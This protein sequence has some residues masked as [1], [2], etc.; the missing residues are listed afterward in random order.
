MHA[1]ARPSGVRDCTTPGHRPRNAG[2]V[3]SEVDDT[4]DALMNDPDAPKPPF[5]AGKLASPAPVVAP[6]PATPAAATA[7]AT[8][9]W[10][11]VTP[12]IDEKS[13]QAVV[14]PP[15]L[16]KLALPTLGNPAMPALGGPPTLGPPSVAPPSPGVA[17]STLTSPTVGVVSATPTAGATSVKPRTRGWTMFMEVTEEEAVAAPTPAAAP[18]AAP[19]LTP[20]V[21]AV[22]P[23]PT[24]PSGEVKPST[25]GW[26]MLMD[27]PAQADPVALVPATPPAAATSPARPTTRGWTMIEELNDSLPADPTPM[28]M[29]TPATTGVASEASGNSNAP[30]SRGWTMLMEAELQQ[31][32]AEESNKAQAGDA[33]PEFF[34]GAVQTESG[35]VIA[36]VPSAA[37]PNVSFKAR[38]E[39]DLSAGEPTTSFGARLRGGEDE[40]PVPQPQIA[41][42]GSGPSPSAEIPS[43][44]GNNLDFVPVVPVVNEAPKARPDV[45]PGPEPDPLDQGVPPT[46]VNN[47]A[48]VISVVVVLVIVAALVL[49][50]R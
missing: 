48:V 45:R 25:R 28:S 2:A 26:T 10:V 47:K 21:A 12:T 43:F 14:P 23:I 13:A 37:E 20:A 29:P 1:A 18:I 36:Y 34:D 16:G 27:D 7:P 3:S 41:P 17:P 4:L 22:A 19:A 42:N 8:P 44:A 6:V 15:G 9:A 11:R 5:D 24:P 50:M 30:S 32:K 49:S 33:E 46:S 31:G 39:L 38:R 40:V 35:M